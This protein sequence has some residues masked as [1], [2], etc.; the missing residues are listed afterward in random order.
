MLIIAMAT[1]QSEH[2]NG[3]SGR[4]EGGLHRDVWLVAASVFRCCAV[5]WGG[6]MGSMQAILS[7]SYPK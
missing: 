2:D 4:E 7:N 5:F 3:N 1:A 6:F